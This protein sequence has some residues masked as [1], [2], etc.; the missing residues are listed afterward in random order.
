MAW[1][2]LVVWKDGNV[3]YLHEG[4]RIATFRR[5]PEANTQREFLLIGMEDDV[6]SINVVKAP[7]ESR[8]GL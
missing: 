4:H 2:V 3:E 5:R 7:K 6:Q 1:A 8:G